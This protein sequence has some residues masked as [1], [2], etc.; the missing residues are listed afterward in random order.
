MHQTSAGI[1]WKHDQAGITACRLH[2]D[3]QREPPDLWPCVE[4][5]T[6]PTLVVRGAKSDYLSAET[7][8]QMMLRNPQFT[9]VEIAG[10]GHYIH[11]DQ[12]QAFIDAVRGF[13]QARV[14]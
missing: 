12:P 14:G 11:D 3:P 2:P 8:A 10:A 6:C 13:L 4:A 9:G 5:I 1:V 7:Y